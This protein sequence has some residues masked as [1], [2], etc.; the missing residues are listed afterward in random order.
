MSLQ[1]DGDARVAI[2]G[3]AAL[4]PGAAD[5]DA[6]WRNLVDGVDAITEVPRARWEPEFFDPEQ[7]HRPD[8]FYC[9]RGGFVDGLAT[10]QPLR[11]GVMPA[12]V[13]AI[14]PDQLI[15]LNVAAAAID[16]AGGPDRLP[17]RERVG[18]LLGRG[19]TLSPGQ[20]RYN[21][22]IRTPNEL[23]GLLRDLLPDLDPAQLERVRE[24]CTEKLGPHRPEDAIGLM[25]NLVASRIAN[26]LDLRGPAYTLD[27]ACAS[28]LLAVDQAV[29]ELTSGRLDA[30]LAGGVHHV[31]DITYWSVFSQL[32][33]LSRKGRIRPFDQE[34][35]GLLIGE[36]TGIVVL[37]RLS[38]ALRDGDRVYA[39]VRGTGVSSDGSGASLVNPSPTGQVLALR[40]AWAAAGLDPT[41]P[42][43]LGLL[44]AHGTATP[45]GDRAELAT[46]AEMF[47]PAGGGRR[48]V[49]GSVKSMIGHTMPAA[50]AAGLIKAALA[51]HHGVLPPTLHCDTPHQDLARTRFAPVGRAEPW[52]GPGPRRA[53]VNAFGFGGINAHVVLEQAP[54]RPAARAGRPGTA[55]PTVAEPDQVL[56][57]GAPD[58]AALARLLANDDRTVRAL[59]ADRARQAGPGTGS[60]SCRIGIVGPTDRRLAAARHLLDLGEPCRGLGDIWFSPEPLLAKGR[61]AFVF[62][63]IEG[64]FSPRTDDLARHFGL[65]ERQRSQTGLSGHIADWIAVGRLLDQALRRI[66]I[67]PDLVAGASIGEWTAA[68]TTGLIGG[69]PA[70]ESLGSLPAAAL[71][72]PGYVFAAVAASATTVTAL[73]GD[74]PGTAVSHDNAPDLCVVNGP[75]AEV[76]RLVTALAKR[77]V[78]SRPLPFRSAFHTPRFA[79]RLRALDTILRGWEVR[80]A[81]VPLW[82]ATIAAPVPPEARRLAELFTRNMLGTVRLRETIAALHQAGARVFLQVGAGNLA[83]VIDDNLR[84]LDHLALPVNVAHRTG[85][86]QLRRVATALWVEGAAPDLRALDTSRG[87]RPQTRA[88]HGPTMRLDLGT[89]LLRLGTGAAG[90]L[91]V[92][93]GTEVP[94]SLPAAACAPGRAPSG[95][96]PLA[97]EFA[98]LV[99]E[100]GDSAA[101][102]LRATEP[103]VANPEPLNVPGYRDTGRHGD[104]LHRDVLRVSLETMPYLND[105]CLFVQP[106]DWP[107]AA[108]RFP[109]VPATTLVQHMMDAAERAAPGRRAVAVR[110]ARF[111]RWLTAAP[112]QDVEVTVHPKA[113][114]LLTVRLGDF[115][116]GTVEVAPGYPPRPPQA[117]PHDPATERPPSISAEAMYA[118][119]IMFHGPRFQGV[120]EIT[121]VGDRHIR[122]VLT[123]PAAPGALLDSALQPGGNWLA[124]TQPTRTVALPV[125]IDR[126]SFFGPLPAA[127]TTLRT[128]TRITEMDDSRIVVDIQVQQG[129]RTLVQLDGYTARRFDSRPPA[130]AAERFPG[131][132][133]MSELQPEGWT[134]VFNSWTDPVSQ[135]LA[136]RAMLGG[137]AYADYEQQPIAA[138]LGW[139]LGRIAAKDAVRFRLW[140]D[141]HPAVF[142]VELTVDADSAGRPLVRPRPGRGFAAHDVAF[143]HAGDIG[144]GIAVPRRPGAPGVGISVVEIPDRTAGSAE[145]ARSRAGFDAVTS[146]AGTPPSTVAPQTAESL[147]AQAADH[148]YRVR[149]RE[150]SNPGHLPSRR[151][152]VAWTTGPEPQQ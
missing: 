75:E 4:F 74:Y 96:S 5:L 42:D 2:V 23:V 66:G 12:S 35:D 50:G 6:Y 109:V 22:R 9:R 28:A 131:S 78:L 126:I 141:E 34:A 82:S 90:L 140:A 130:R 1:D 29:A 81:E 97:A 37:K 116:H 142:P 55:R 11:F 124:D 145:S 94:A 52:E 125:A 77:Q 69:P 63:G 118:E 129:H 134:A 73:L 136:A 40:R 91:T 146:A 68:V 76:E 80:A 3:M 25:P 60:E 149:F 88:S 16:D 17:D 121:A 19:G 92:P 113:P 110:D 128:F 139:L 27:A 7:A 24:R 119:R 33:A 61:L 20:N 36:G 26:R 95:R 120:T 111:H 41:A 84:G 39:V 143:A 21:Q 31:H 47:G 67:T 44:E 117:W 144:V 123:S 103:A 79:E 30:V 15:A 122:A 49:I 150:I 53:G 64:D 38:D 8:R 106:V 127:G 98:A 114:G 58:R 32:G 93:P 87:D 151:Y 71:E 85:L 70:E 99:Q 13:P 59:G 57:L 112:A 46:L 101:R 65:P 51:V 138:R 89:R 133:A 104:Q 56:W 18:V 132:N 62:P 152:V 48:A 102:V 107:H 54:G 83:S 43:A 105:H 148:R 14:E 147:T 72:V 45:T 100:A 135:G 137:R 10:F 108:D 86:D 115:A